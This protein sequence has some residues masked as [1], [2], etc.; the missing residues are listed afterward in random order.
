MPPGK[1]T[2]KIIPNKTHELAANHEQWPA[3]KQEFKQSANET[4]QYVGMKPY[5][6]TTGSQDTN[7]CSDLNTKEHKAD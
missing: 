1:K 7:S 4:P 3:Q 6:K 2:Q 5:S